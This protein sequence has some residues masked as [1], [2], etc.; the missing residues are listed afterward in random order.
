MDFQ[1]IKGD[2]LVHA[3][4][5]AAKSKTSLL[6]AKHEIAPDTK[7]INIQDINDAFDQ[8]D[9]GDGGC[10]QKRKPAALEFADK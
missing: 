10:R 1:Y 8:L 5:Y 6:N 7:L 3:I 4:G 9:H 2:R